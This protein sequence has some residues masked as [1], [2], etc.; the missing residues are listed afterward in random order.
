MKCVLRIHQSFTD[1]TLGAI[2]ATGTGTDVG[3]H[4]GP[5]IQTDGV[6]ESCRRHMETHLD[7]TDLYFKLTLC[8][9]ECTLGRRC[10][11]VPELHV[12]PYQP[13]VH[14]QTSGETHSPP[15]SQCLLHTTE[16]DT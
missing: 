16:T 11:V 13:G 7:S 8:F 2:E 1:L 12:G 4:A 14:S 9:A 15:F 10:Y 6:T 3:L 5:S